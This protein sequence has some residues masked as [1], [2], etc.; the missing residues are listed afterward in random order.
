MIIYL[1]GFMGSGKS[2]AGKKLAAA[3][4]YKFIDLDELIEEEMGVTI[5]EIFSNEGEPF[6]RARESEVLRR[7][8]QMANTVIACGGG[9]P[10]YH[11][12]MD[13]MNKAGL[14][15]YLEMTPGQLMGRLSKSGDKRPL[16]S[17]LKDDELVNY[18]SKTLAE[19]EPFY[20]KSNILVTGFDLN[21]SKLV[22]SIRENLPS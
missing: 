16:I 8:G 12:N 20:R 10:C 19:R 11:G 6:F 2:T 9:T 15:V 17:S 22:K 3:L 4:E 21:I 5:R 18:I 7:T 14:T 1:L 13:Y